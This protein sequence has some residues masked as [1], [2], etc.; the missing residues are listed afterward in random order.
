M[1]S[2]VYLLLEFAVNGN[3]FWYIRRQKSLTEQRAV[4]L[5]KQTCE[6]IRYLHTRGFIHRDLK[7]ENILLD[8]DFRVKVCDFGWCT[9]FEKEDE[10]RKTFCG[11]YEYMAPEIYDKRPYDEK[12]DIWALGIL[13]YELLHGKSP[14]RGNSVIDIYKNIQREEVKFSSS[15]SPEARDLIARILKKLPVSRLSMDQILDHPLIRKYNPATSAPQAAR[16]ETAASETGRPPKSP[17]NMQDSSLLKNSTVKKEAEK[18]LKE[19]TTNLSTAEPKKTPATGGGSKHHFSP[20]VNGFGS[21]FM[22]KGTDERKKS[23]DRTEKESD[24]SKSK[25]KHLELAAA[26]QRVVMGRELPPKPSGHESSKSGL[27]TS[28]LGRHYHSESQSGGRMID[29]TVAKNQP[30]GGEYL[31][32]GISSKPAIPK[33]SSLVDQPLPQRS[34]SSDNRQVLKPQDKYFLDAACR[35]IKRDNVKSLSRASNKLKQTNNCKTFDEGNSVPKQPSGETLPENRK[36]SSHDM[37]TGFE[38]KKNSVYGMELPREKSDHGLNIRNIIGRKMIDTRRQVPLDNKSSLDYTNQSQLKPNPLE[39]SRTH[40]QS[41]YSPHDM[42]K[43]ETAKTKNKAKACK[44]L[45]DR[46]SVR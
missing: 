18:C 40:Q 33:K 22:S 46:I 23:L 14:F 1:K 27:Q 29:S 19:D 20:T 37:K 38:L 15:C 12:V 9:E 17:A 26:L 16:V 4:E 21:Y 30:T 42:S 35:K 6:A 5:F 13:L 31:M 10:M 36:Q 24:R 25:P 32:A 2:K 44:E 7:P 39:Q 3:L 28:S 41:Q 11:T 8:A 45:L 34:G 43:Y